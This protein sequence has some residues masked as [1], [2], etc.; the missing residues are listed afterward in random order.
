MAALIEELIEGQDTFELIRDQIAAILTLESEGQQALA[1]LAN[2]D[3]RG[4][5]LRVFL[6]RM[7]PWAEFIDDPKQA[8][9]TPVVNVTW[10]QLTPDMAASSVVSGSKCVGVY[11]VDCYGYGISADVQDGGHIPGDQAAGI[12][13]ARVVRLVRRI[14]LSGHYTYLGLPRK[15]VW[16]RWLQSVTALNPPIGERAVQHVVCARMT[17]AVDFAET[18]PQVQGHPLTT[19]AVHVKRASDGHL[20]FDAQYGEDS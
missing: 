12:E 11:N 20:Y 10:E 14:L 19:L 16:R 7:N 1:T 8:D 15:T 13:A 17:F 18:S 6:E 5:K 4:W 9:A 2:E 3:P